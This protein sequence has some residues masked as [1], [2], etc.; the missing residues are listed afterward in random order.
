MSV[1]RS[2]LFGTM[3][4][5]WIAMC[6]PL[7]FLFLL[8]SRAVSPI[9][10]VR[11]FCVPMRIGHMVNEGGRQII[12]REDGIQGSPRRRIITFCYLEN[13]TYTNKVAYRELKRLARWVNLPRS[14]GVTSIHLARRIR[15]FA[16][17]EHR[18]PGG[19]TDDVFFQQKWTHTFRPTSAERDRIASGLM[20]LGV[21]IN[22]R[23]AAFLV[24][25]SN[26]LST[27]G[28]NDEHLKRH[29]H[30]DCRIANYSE[31]VATAIC[32]G[33][34]CLR[35]G[36]ETGNSNAEPIVGLVGYSL[37][38]IQSDLLDVA[39]AERASVIFTCSSGLDCLYW[40][41]GAAH[42][43]VNLQWLDGRFEHFITAL[44][45]RLFVRDGERRLEL[46]ILAS[47]MP[48]FQIGTHG[49]TWSGETVE[50]QENSPSEIAEVVD[51]AL[52]MLD[53]AEIREQ[54]ISIAAP[55]WREFNQRLPSSNLPDAF[56][57]R[58]PR[59]GLPDSVMSRFLTT[60]A[61]RPR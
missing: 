42:V 47:V 27:L 22:S 25:D 43:G 56:K 49:A 11:I 5:F 41:Y 40:L 26:Y 54:R 17:V 3:R 13:P 23:I 4:R 30:R 15:W 60:D 21:H 34:T 1:K 55:L 33:Y 36:R 38:N 59:F 32:R 58:F 61:I 19:S 50:F 14:I 44:P 2:G 8:I 52:T 9:V 10:T 20:E 28:T 37:H 51:L 48:D 16:V 57:Q 29:A 7:A 45:K 39:L 46:P 35:V 12:E 53:D 24:R 31:G 6:I 18:A